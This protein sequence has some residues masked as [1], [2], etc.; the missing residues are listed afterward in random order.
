MS[1]GT[2]YVL[3]V[4]G[5]PVAILAIAMLAGH[6]HRDD[7]ERL[8][9]WT[10]TRSPRREAELQAGDVQQMLGAVN[11]YRRMRGA[12]E[13]SLEQVTEHTWASLERYEG[14]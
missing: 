12:S 5:L 13:R 6:F 3:M 10:P 1:D 9:D 2:Y 4:V 7:D 14:P 11:R 8:L